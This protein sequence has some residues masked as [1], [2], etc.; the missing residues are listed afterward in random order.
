[1]IFL[2]II[3]PTYNRAHLISE[4]VK[5]ALLQ[6]YE[7]FEI[8][9]VDD[10]STDNTRQVVEG[11]FFLDNRV[12]YFYKENEERGAA[13]NFGLKE[14]KGDYAVFFDS[15]D[16]MKPGYLSV[17]A[18]II[19]KNENIFLLAGHYNFITN[20][21]KEIKAPVQQLTE[22]WYDRNYFLTGNILACNYCIRIKDKQYEFFP[23]ERELASMED[24]LFLFA[25]LQTE[26]IFISNEVCLSMRQHNERTMANNQ[27]VIEARKK[28][29]DWIIKN[30]DLGEI[31]KKKLKAW[32]HY[33]CGIH[34]YLD[35]KRIGAVK[36][37]I[38]AIR[39][40][41]IN[42]KFLLLLSKSVIGRKLIQAIR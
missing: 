3:I 28:A 13:R 1:M 4:S 12:R 16:L 24:W 38:A 30:L 33:F 17:L 42:K 14:A 39:L 29:T 32:S 27:K 36:E 7:P 18:A 20:N 26:K 22:G 8:I 19:G 6:L 35:H 11:N 25:N 34:Q 15:D 9:I 23:F 21:G 31:E 2:S 5:S 41:G 40:A 37:S 10:G